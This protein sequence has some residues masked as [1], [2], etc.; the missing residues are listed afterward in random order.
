M[1]IKEIVRS[2]VRNVKI[3][4]KSLIEYSFYKNNWMYSKETREKVGYNIMLD[5]HSLEKG[6]TVENPRIFGA[7]KV[8]T[9]IDCLTK[10]EANAWQKDFA[11]YTGI[12]ILTQYVDFFEKHNWNDSVEYKKAKKF[13]ADEHSSIN[14][15]A[16]KINRSDFLDDSQIDYEKFLKSR[17]SFRNFA[18]KKITST[19]MKKAVKMAILSPSA[20][21]RQ[22]CK[23]YYVKSDKTKNQ[24]LRFSHG[25]TNFDND[26]VNLI[27]ITYD[28]SS[29]CHFG[30]INQGMFNAGLFAMNLVNSLHSLGIGSCFL[31]Y[32]DT[33]DEELEMKK[34]V[35]ISNSERIAIVLAAGYYPEESI[36]TCSTRKPLEEVYRER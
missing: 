24:I 4:K 1:K 29:F 7:S 22:M 28:L 17:H 34:I 27:I 9:I 23:A 11:Y 25:L 16:Y 3:L 20:C 14:T 10:Y 6:M 30:E 13:I 36:I 8:M 2:H 21:N 35:G 18:S 33:K 19:D 31:E 26:T 32:N 15:G 5:A 12:S